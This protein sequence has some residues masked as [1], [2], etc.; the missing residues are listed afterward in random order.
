MSDLKQKLIDHIH[1][2]VAWAKVGKQGDTYAMDVEKTDK[3]A[4]DMAD[5][6]IQI[7][8][9]D[10]AGRKPQTSM[11]EGLTSGRVQDLPVPQRLLLRQVAIGLLNSPPVMEGDHDYDKEIHEAETAIL[12]LIGK[13]NSEEY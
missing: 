8:N 11:S 5:Y 10:A 12:M 9:E 2:P 7:L 6:A 3:L 13:L 4:E 1:R